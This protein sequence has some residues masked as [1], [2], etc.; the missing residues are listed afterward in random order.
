MGNF[1]ARSSCKNLHASHFLL[2]SFHPNSL[3][4]DLKLM[5]FIW[6]M[7]LLSSNDAV[8]SPF[9]HGWGRLQVSSQVTVGWC[10]A[11]GSPC[12]GFGRASGAT[13]PHVGRQSQAGAARLSLAFPP[14]LFTFWG[15]PCALGCSVCHRVLRTHLQPFPKEQW[16][17]FALQLFQ[18]LCPV[19]L[20]P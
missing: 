5:V 10:A 8:T 2:T 4:Q 7:D 16:K 11:W 17:G 13:R 3:P 19:S 20:C 9:L 15:A 18:L 14:W 6:E 1:H 12:L